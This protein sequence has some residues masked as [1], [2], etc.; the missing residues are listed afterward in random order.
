MAQSLSY[1]FRKEIEDFEI[2]ME[3]KYK[4]DNLDE[5]FFENENYIDQLIENGFHPSSVEYCIKYDVFD[6]FAVVDN[7]NQEAR[8]SHFEWSFKPQYLICYRLPDF[9]AQSSSLSIC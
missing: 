6:D 2:F 7:A 9:L 3:N 5:L 1:C 8:W 4:P